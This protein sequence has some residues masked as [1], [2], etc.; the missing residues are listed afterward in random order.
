M[1]SFLY[2]CWDI[3]TSHAL[4]KSPW[5]ALSRWPNV[6]DQEEADEMSDMGGQIGKAS[7]VPLSAPVRAIHV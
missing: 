7:I 4:V 3:F 6:P 5:P 1:H 2:I